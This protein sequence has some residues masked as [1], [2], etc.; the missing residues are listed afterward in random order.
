LPQVRR[1]KRIAQ[2]TGARS[3]ALLSLLKVEAGAFPEEA[4]EEH[5]AGLDRRDRA[6]AAALVYGVLRWRL[7]L[8]W[9]VKRF[10]QNPERP[11]DPPVTNILR[12][13]LFQLHYLD[14]IPPSAA[15]NESV[16]LARAYG[17]AWSVKLVNAVLRAVTRAKYPPQPADSVRP[18]LEALAVDQAHPPWLLKRWFKELGRE[19]ALALT[20]ANNTVPPLTLRINPARTSREELARLLAGAAERI[21]AA[22]YSPSGLL[23]YGPTGP[24]TV[25]PGYEEGLF[26]VQDEASQIV[27][28]LAAPTSKETVL[29]ACTGRGGKALHL[30]GLGAGLVTALD[31]DRTRLLQG[32]N[33]ARRLG[34]DPLVF[35]QGDLIESSPFRP[36]SFD[37]VLVDAPCSNLGVIRRRPDIKWLK[38]P[39]DPARLAGLQS[40]LLAA[41][42][43]LVRPG[44]RLIYAVCT[45]T[46]EETTGVIEKFQERHPAFALLPAGDFLPESARSL[47]AGDGLVRAWPHRHHTDGFFGA[48]FRKKD[49]DYAAAS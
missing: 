13:G 37:L 28:L 31:P 11:L 21:E 1:R 7:R 14:R 23:L 41:A 22:P 33:E 18:D 48:V 27:G 42:A 38:A 40:R 6:L 2:A 15:V 46:P 35:I 36:E 17:P 43:V 4:L 24:V 34:L 20:A 47:V 12:L 10:L 25:L 32:R 45:L 3:A 16:K 9:T 26:A 29:D 8:D 39:P 5:A 19:E 49:L 30:A 44:G